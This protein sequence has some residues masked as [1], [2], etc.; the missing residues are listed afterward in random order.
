MRISFGLLKLVPLER[1]SYVFL[2]A[3]WSPVA[4]LAVLSSFSVT[5]TFKPETTRSTSLKRAMTIDL[6]NGLCRR[7]N[8][9]RGG[10]AAKYSLWVIL[11]SFVL[12]GTSQALG[13][14][15]CSKGE[16]KH[17]LVGHRVQT[18]VVIYHGAVPV[19]GVHARYRITGVKLEGTILHV[20]LGTD[21][22][23]LQ[24]LPVSFSPRACDPTSIRDI[25]A[26]DLI[27]E[28]VDPSTETVGPQAQPLEQSS[29]PIVRMAGTASAAMAEK[30]MQAPGATSL[31]ERVSADRLSKIREAIAMRESQNLTEML[32]AAFPVS[33]ALRSVY[34][35][36]SIYSGSAQHP[37]VRAI[38]ELRQRLG[39]SLKPH[40]VN[41]VQQLIALLEESAHYLPDKVPSDWNLAR[42]AAQSAIQAYSTRE[43]EIK[44]AMAL[45]DEAE[46]SLDNAEYR[47]AKEAYD[48]LASDFFANDAPIQQY[49]LLTAALRSDLA[50]YQRISEPD[51][52]NLSGL[53]KKTELVA[54]EDELEKTCQGKP[55]SMALLQKDKPEDVDH[56]R[57]LINGIAPVTV[58]ED[59]AILPA[60]LSTTT[61]T[62]ATEQLAFIQDRIA[63]IDSRLEPSK[64][65]P[66]VLARPDL[67]STVQ[68]DL[69]K[70]AVDVLMVRSSEIAQ[71]QKVRTR[72]ES[73]AQD[74]K[75]Q[76][77][78][79]EEAA[80]VQ[81]QKAEQARAAQKA[82]AEEAQRKREEEAAHKPDPYAP[83]DSA[84]RAAAR[85][86][87]AGLVGAR[88]RSLLLNDGRVDPTL[89]SLRVTT[90]TPKSPKGQVTRDDYRLE[91]QTNT[92]SLPRDVTAMLRNK[93]LNDDL[94]S[95]GFKEVS[96]Q[97]TVGVQLGTILCQ[98]QL[99]ATGAHPGFCMRMELVIGS[100]G[101][102]EWNEYH[103]W[104]EQYV[105][106]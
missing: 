11:L 32:N 67:M 10:V 40:D 75:L 23:D 99:L 57:K 8:T 18:L 100:G 85:R 31:S 41:D 54:Q 91:I 36:T 24:E 25:L 22:G 94:F 6:L 104:P 86:E 80:R 89:V 27:F 96:F 81:L 95:L 87:F 1:S 102:G 97:D 70:S 45:I 82:A 93:M 46:R 105:V 3:K 26:G 37:T 106:P 78:K 79:S 58:K 53:V 39:G 69:G 50:V 83:P 2:R 12:T 61:P 16:L 103:R 5:L 47:D 14:A 90:S 28:D 101:E 68:G 29:A 38:A 13:Q 21:Y 84:S 4:L 74:D 56:L 92:I 72:L 33:K 65:I 64:E 63:S 20:R 15:A 73:L 7:L 66:A 62:N 35:A 52:K 55:L 9:G 59:E 60:R 49:L 98:V 19:V 77:Q 42:A 71:A 48:H 76:I 43:E 34:G 88:L 44:R 17:A 51:R 30:T